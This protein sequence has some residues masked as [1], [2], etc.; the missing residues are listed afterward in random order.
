MPRDM[1]QSQRDQHRMLPLVQGPRGAEFIEMRSRGGAAAGGSEV[2]VGVPGAKVPVREDE[3]ALETAVG[4][5]CHRCER[6]FG[7]T[8]TYGRGKEAGKGAS[9]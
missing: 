6:A 4:T 9:S 2:G 5:R 3:Q 8:A 7:T 1:S